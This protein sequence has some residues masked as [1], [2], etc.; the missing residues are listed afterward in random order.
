[1]KDG[2]QFIVEEYRQHNKFLMEQIKEKNIE[3]KKLRND[4]QQ[5]KEK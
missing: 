5:Y 3:L 2:W 1:M 4:L